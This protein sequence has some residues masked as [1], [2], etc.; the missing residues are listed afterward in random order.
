VPKRHRS[1]D[2]TAMAPDGAEIR[3]LIDREQGA[4]RL[5]LAEAL[6]PPGQRTAKVF[7]ATI[8]EEI[9]YIVRGRGLMRLHDPALEAEE[10]LEVVPGDAVLIPPGHG[11]WVD[12]P[13]PDDLVFLCCG[14][15]PWPGSQEAQP[16]PPDM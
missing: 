11:F 13:G 4:T 7:H 12:N 10:A 15:P 5:S 8:Y 9:W 6:V 16:W 1:D 14:S 2:I 3:N